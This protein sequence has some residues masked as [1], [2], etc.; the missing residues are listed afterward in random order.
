MMATVG[1]HAE[2]DSIAQIEFPGFLDLQVNGFGGVDFN[3]PATTNRDVGQAVQ[4]MRTTGVTRLLPTLITSPFERFAQCA[5][6]LAR[7]G[8]PEIFGIHM[9]GPYICPDAGARG[10]HPREHAIPASIEDFARRQDAAD[11]RILL[12]TLAPDVPGALPLIEHL[13]DLGIRVAIGHTAAS[14]EQIRDAVTA[15]ATLST[16]MGNG[17]AHSLPRHPNFIWEQLATDELFASLIVDGH[18]LPA[19]TVK[20][21]VRAKTAERVFLVTDAVAAAGCAPGT[22]E[23]NGE[24]VVSGEDGRVSPVGKPWLAGSTL[25]MSQAVGNTVKFTGLPL[26]TVLAMA[27]TLPAKYLGIE[28]VGTVT[29]NWNASRC[30]LSNIQAPTILKG[31]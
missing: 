10:A 14:P 13:V 22:Y 24:R 1:M 12:V 8:L 2:L 16:H 19:A 23:L 11:G 29:A 27:S 21:M 15:G 17:C 31:N 30:R 28:P 4:A 6:T 20:A 5:R 25:T 26:E 3:N 9:E 7:A 18:H